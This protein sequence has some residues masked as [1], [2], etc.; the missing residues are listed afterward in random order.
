VLGAGERETQVEKRAGFGLRT[1]RSGALA[2]ETEAAR[3]MMER[4]RGRMVAAMEREESDQL[5]EEAP[6]G[7]VVEDDEGGAA[8]ED[9]QESPGHPG[10]EEQTPTGDEG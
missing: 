5:P 9:A 3:R 6:P 8:R 1:T 10:E 4:L 2:V 7:Q